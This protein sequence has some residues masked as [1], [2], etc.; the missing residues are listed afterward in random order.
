MPSE[1]A[2]HWTLDPA[3][4]FINHGSYGAAPRGVLAAQQ[5]WRERMEAEPV[6]FFSQ[7]LEP[8]MDAARRALG[9][10]GRAPR[11]GRRRRGMTLQP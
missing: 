5:A 2:R 3:V 11:S 1:F 10:F 6:R 9:T 7:D 8:A 4:A